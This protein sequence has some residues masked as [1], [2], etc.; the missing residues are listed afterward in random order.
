M[1]HL[2]KRH[3][4]FD[5]PEINECSEG[6]HAPDN[7]FNLFADLEARQRLGPRFA[8]FILDNCFARKDH[9][10]PALRVLR[11]DEGKP[12]ADE[13]AESAPMCMSMCDPGANARSPSTSTSTPPLITPVTSPR[14]SDASVNA[15]S[16]VTLVFSA[17]RGW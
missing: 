13:V 9:V 1:A 11:D 2:L 7:S 4:A 3:Q 17:R 8:R 14:T 15:F 5:P 10:A 6:H 12:L 16:R